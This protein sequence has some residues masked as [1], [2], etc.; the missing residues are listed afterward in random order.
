MS[1]L[2]RQGREKALQLLMSL[3]GAMANGEATSEKVAADFWE[4]SG[5]SPSLRRFTN[6]LFFGAAKVQTELDPVIIPALK[7]WRIER[8]SPVDRNLL[9]LAVYE[10]RHCPE[11]PP[12]VVLNEYIEIAKKFGEGGSGGLVNGVLDAIYKGGAALAGTAG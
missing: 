12:K 3:E 2:R 11:V 5:G 4:A 8:L 1:G 7:N 10:L 6:E 9:R